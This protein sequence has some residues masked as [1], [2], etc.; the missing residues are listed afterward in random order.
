MNRRQINGSRL[1]KTARW[2]YHESGIRSV[3]VTGRDSWLIILAR[4]CRMFAFGGTSLIMA[5][6][7]TTL[8]FSD[9]QL[10]LFMT[11]TLAGDTVLSFGLTFIADS[12]GRRRVFF[13]A[14]LL[15]AVS[16]LVFVYFDSFWILLLAAVV[17]VV[18]ANGGDFGPFR[19]IEESVL[20]HLTTPETRSDVLSWYVVTSNL[21]SA[22]GTEVAGRVVEALKRR[23]G[24]SESRV[25]H[26]VFAAYIIMGVA[27]MGFSYFMTDN[28]EITKPA[29]SMDEGAQTAQGLLSDSDEEAGDEMVPPTAEPP[30]PQKRSRFTEISSTTRSVM[31]KLWFLLTVDCLADGMVSYTLTNYYLDRKFHLSKSQLGDLMSTNYILGSISTVFAG[32]LARHLGLVNTMVFTHLPSSV[33]VLLFPA[34]QGIVLTVILLFIRGGLNNMDQAPRTAFIAAAVKPGERTAVMGITNTLR[35]L[36]SLIGPSI[37]G[38]LADT[39]KF[40]VAFVAAGALRVAYDLGLWA[41]F[42]NVKLHEHEESSQDTSKA[43]RVAD[44]EDSME[45]RPFKEEEE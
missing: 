30:V 28:C 40:W 27:N 20:S 39:D 41:M 14:G 18:S 17:G 24:W 21:G 37:T 38:A 29:L 33:A 44:E 43:R 36:A 1:H 31:Y 11:M 19:A 32:P 34:P 42:V 45:M 9:P 12:L 13:G 2:L 8:G 25:Y 22:V 5:L 3:H 35:T 26:T 10:G 16:G 23:D 6:F 15:M 7:F 4:T